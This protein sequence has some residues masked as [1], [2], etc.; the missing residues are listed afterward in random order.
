MRTALGTVMIL[1]ALLVPAAAAGQSAADSAAEAAAETADDAAVDAGEPDSAS[2]LPAP[3]PPPP[4][5]EAEPASSLPKAIRPKIT[6]TVDKRR[7]GLGESVALEIAIRH[8]ADQ[9]YHLPQNADFGNLDL[10]HKSVDAV[11]EEGGWVKEVFKF[12]LIALEP[13]HLEIPSLRFGGVTKTGDVVYL[14][15]KPVGLDV[16]DPTTGKPDARLKAAAPTVKVYEKNYLL[17]WFLGIMAGVFLVIALVWYMA[18]NWER[19]HPR[20][21]LAPPPPR[22]P[23]LVAYEKLQELR[24]RMPDE[25]ESKKIWYVDLSE[26]MREYLANRFDFDALESTSEEIIEVMKMKKTVGITQAELWKFLVNC[27]MVKFAKHASSGDEDRETL[28]EAFRIVHATTP[29][30]EEERR[31]A[32]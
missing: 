13:G 5:V 11:K 1:A 21:P 25:R 6:T 31:G 3:L 23:E 32:P 28:D 20:A 30:R 12:E 4:E 27:D 14:E 19:W 17:L 18:R 24:S 2:V 10:L 16:R 29:K 22:P 26:V 7:L 8:K 9:K 15:S